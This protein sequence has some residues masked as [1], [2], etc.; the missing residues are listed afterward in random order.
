MN[1]ARPILL[2]LHACDGIP[3]PESALLGAVRNLSVPHR[4]TNSDIGA[5]LRAVEELGYV[6]GVTDEL[7]GARTWTLTEKGKH[8]AREL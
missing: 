7:D 5:A 8:R 6:K 1:L 2:A 3:M 4:P